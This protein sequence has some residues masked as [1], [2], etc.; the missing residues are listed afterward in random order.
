MKRNLAIL[1]GHAIE[2]VVG[3]EQVSIEVGKVNQW[4]EVCCCRDRT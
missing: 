4:R 2:A 1:N 3:D